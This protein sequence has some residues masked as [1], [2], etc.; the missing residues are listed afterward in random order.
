MIILRSAL[1]NV[2]FYTITALVALIAVP[3]LLA[4]ATIARQLGI[5]WGWF[6][7]QLLVIAGISHRLSGDKHLNRQVIYAAKHQSAWETMSLC[8]HLNA[9]VI[10]L[11]KELLRLPVI[12]WLMQKAGVI[13]VDRKAGM[14]ALKQ[15]KSDAMAAAATGR[16]IQIYPQGT[17]V[18]TGAKADYQIGIYAIYQATNLPVVPIAL[19]SAQCWG[20][21][22]FAKKPG[23]ID[24]VFL[25]AIPAGLSRA[26]FME[27]LETVIET[28]TAKLEQQ[29]QTHG[30]G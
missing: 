16:S 5:F 14:K 10:V 23:M 6:T 27:R 3:A 28:Q 7:N 26:Q 25:P 24:V 8:W 30:K 22:A 13:A 18:P 29:F 21:R 15:L 19:N 17:R 4:P 1:F 12:G 2:L 11:K 9:P 20:P